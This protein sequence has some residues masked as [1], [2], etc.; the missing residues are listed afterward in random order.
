MRPTTTTASYT[1]RSWSGPAY[2]DAYSS[3]IKSALFTKLFNAGVQNF[4]PVSASVTWLDLDQ[5]IM[6]AFWIRPL[7]TAPSLIEW[8]N[9]I[10]TVS[11]SISVAGLVDQEVGW[12][13]S[14]VVPSGS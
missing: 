9:S 5:E 10:S 2:P 13:A 4:N 14:Q 11:S 8:S 6:N 1:A 3:G 7:F 12:L